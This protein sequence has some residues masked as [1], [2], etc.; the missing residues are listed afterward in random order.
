MA[1]KLKEG[2]VT[3]LLAKIRQQKTPT[4]L[5]R[6]KHILCA[7]AIRKYIAAKP[8]SW[9]DVEVRITEEELTKRL[10]PSSPEKV[11]TKKIK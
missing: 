1:K 5:A 8:D 6:F 3:T 9:L 11:I 2:K 10:K 4:L 7:Q